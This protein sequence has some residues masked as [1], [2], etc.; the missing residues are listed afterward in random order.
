MPIVVTF[1][2]SRP[3]PRELNRL[4]GV[5]ERLGW[6][7]LGN[8]AY[9]Y[10]PLGQEPDVEDWLNRVAP[11]LMLLR[12]YSRFAAADQRGIV[13]LTIDAHTSTGFSQEAGVGAPPLPAD[14][15][16]YSHPSDAGYDFSQQR[17][18]AWLDGIEWPYA[19]PAVDAAP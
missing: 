2:L 5:F 4:R 17:L 3:L 14:A 1:D 16:D 7:R 12:A 18:Q 13:R 10:P 9:R 11:A 6:Q 8:T 19:P 15:I